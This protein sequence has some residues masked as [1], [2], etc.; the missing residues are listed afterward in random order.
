MFLAEVPDL[1]VDMLHEVVALG[2]GVGE[3]AGDEESHGVPAR[4]PR[5]LRVMLPQ[6]PPN[7]LLPW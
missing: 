3:G 2:L 6:N 4:H 5:G 1:G 7:Q